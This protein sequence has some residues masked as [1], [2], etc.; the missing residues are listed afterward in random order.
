[1]RALALALE[2]HGASSAAVAA[3]AIDALA[4]LLRGARR[5][6]AAAA[7]AAAAGGARGRFW[8]RELYLGGSGARGGAGAPPPLLVLSGHAASV[9]PY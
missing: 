6:R 7:A 9:T 2:R 1:V 5:A 4:R 8:R 3:Q